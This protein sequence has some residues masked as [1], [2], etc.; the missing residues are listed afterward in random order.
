MKTPSQP[1]AQRTIDA[2]L[3]AAEQHFDERGVSA[4]TMRLLAKVTGLSTGAIYQWFPTKAALIDAVAER[5]VRILG[6]ELLER[7]AAVSDGPWRLLIREVLTA[8][9]EGH[10]SRPRMHRF[11][12]EEASRSSVVQALLAALE[13]RL[14]ALLAA[15]LV[16][17][18]GQTPDEAR[19][20]AAMAVRAGNAL[21]HQY[22]LDEALPDD[23]DTRLNRAI[24]ATI[25]LAQSQDRRP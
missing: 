2:I 11:L 7:A 13:S 25:R 12:F 17:E 18:E 21:L 22:V 10:C 20:H 23:A 15:R 3:D 9:K 6:A 19:H 8:S 16:D 1:R 14:E 24:D 4:T 5:H